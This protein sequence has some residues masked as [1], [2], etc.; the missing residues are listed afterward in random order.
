M[1]LVVNPFVHL[2]WKKLP[3]V[4]VN[5]DATSAFANSGR[6]HVLGMQALLASPVTSFS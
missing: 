5:P 4:K 1:L 6:W 2:T 3:K